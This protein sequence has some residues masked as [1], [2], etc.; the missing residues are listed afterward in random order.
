MKRKENGMGDFPPS[1]SQPNT[2]YQ[3]KKIS[4]QIFIN[5]TYVEDNILLIYSLKK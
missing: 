2:N 4:N 1:P 5:F 3:K